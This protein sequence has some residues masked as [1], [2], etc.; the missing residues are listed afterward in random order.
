MN[1]F[2]NLVK[3]FLVEE[4][5]RGGVGASG[6]VGALVEASSLPALN[7]RTGPWPASSSYSPMGLAGGLTQGLR[8]AQD[9]G[10][11]AMK[12]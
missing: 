12:I 3:R 9:P 1:T 6:G 7:P 10:A 2:M 8:Q 5:T 4:G 11:I